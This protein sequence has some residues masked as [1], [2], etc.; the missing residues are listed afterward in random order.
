MKIKKEDVLRMEHEI[1]EEDNIWDISS[2]ELK[3][4]L[5]YFYHGAHHMANKIIEQLE[6]GVDNV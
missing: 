4:K 3:L 2:D 1:I 5:I 6:K